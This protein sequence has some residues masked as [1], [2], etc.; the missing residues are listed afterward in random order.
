VTAIPQPGD[1]LLAYYRT[2]QTTGAPVSGSG[3]LPQ[4][5]CSKAGLSTNSLTMETLGNCTLG[6]SL[7]FPGDRLEIQFDWALSGAVADAFDAEVLWAGIPIFS[8][9]F[10]AGDTTATGTVRVSV[11]DSTRQYSLQSYGV[12]SPLVVSTGT[13]DIPQSAFQVLLRGR[14]AADEDAMLTLTNYSVIRFPRV[15]GQ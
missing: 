11:G 8:R 6:G 12:V 9:S 3:L 10:Q 2:F 14:L 7:L 15:D 4:V 1:V 5:L 13:L